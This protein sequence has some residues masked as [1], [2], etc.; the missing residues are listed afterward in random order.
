MLIILQLLIEKQA[1]QI[2]INS[3]SMTVDGV[4]KRKK[5]FVFGEDD[6]RQETRSNDYHSRKISNYLFWNTY[7]KGLW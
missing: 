1:I 3:G 5:D 6:L 7:A 2:A 4:I